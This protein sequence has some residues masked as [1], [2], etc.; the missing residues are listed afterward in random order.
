[1][2]Q[3]P[4]KAKGKTNANG[5]EMRDKNRAFASALSRV[6]ASLSCNELKLDAPN[7]KDGIPISG[8]IL[9]WFEV[10]KG[11]DSDGSRG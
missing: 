10:T 9:W 5:N 7:G 6:F 1:M 4:A 11:R 3:E 8:M 2:G